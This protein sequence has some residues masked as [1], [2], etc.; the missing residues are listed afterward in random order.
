M[1]LVREVWVK[2]RH[3]QAFAKVFVPNLVFD[4]GADAIVD[5]IEETFG[6]REFSW[7]VAEPLSTGGG[8]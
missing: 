3:W 8:A 6:W 5:W 4:L 2:Q 7:E 1:T